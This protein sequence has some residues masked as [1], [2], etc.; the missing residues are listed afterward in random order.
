MISFSQYLNFKNYL[1]ES[2]VDT[3]KQALSPQIFEFPASENPKLKSAVID[4]IQSGIS[5]LKDK[6]DVIDYVLIGSILTLRYNDQTDLDITV[7]VDCDEQ[8]LK[9]LRKFVGEINEIPV[10]GTEHPVNY[11]VIN[12]REGFNRNLGF[13]DGVFDIRSNRFLR[14]PE[15]KEFS[16]EKYWDAF[17][18]AASEIDITK[19]ELR[20][21]AFDYEE[22]KGLERGLVQSLRDRLEAKIEEMEEGAQEL[23]KLYLQIKQDRRDAFARDMTAK[24]LA[25]YGEKNRLPENVIY[26]LLERYHYLDFLHRVKEI[27]GDDKELSPSE[28][29]ELADFVSQ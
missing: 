10:P 14:K 25:D 24:D 4:Q 7:L 20:Q 17:R 22:L 28:A 21:D 13:A 6:V 15:L 3:V 19:G 2:I 8:Q 16:V 23:T 1:A 26:K 29:D 5:L 18:K 12:T 11:F 9:E 27:L